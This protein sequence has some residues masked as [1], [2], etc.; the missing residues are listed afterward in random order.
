MWFFIHLFRWCLCQYE[1][2]FWRLDL[3]LC[4]P[5]FLAWIPDEYSWREGGGCC[6]WA[7]T[8]TRLFEDSGTSYPPG[9]GRNFPN[10]LSWLSWVDYL[11]LT[12]LSWLAWQWWSSIPGVAW[13]SWLT[14]ASSQCWD[15]VLTRPSHTS[16]LI[17]TPCSYFVQTLW[18]ISIIIVIT[19]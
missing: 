10:I 13:N 1:K 3:S 19:T 4:L 7:R 17:I 11:E 6:C 5:D 8:R 12:I 18:N 2:I 15:F 16:S 14:L 9:L